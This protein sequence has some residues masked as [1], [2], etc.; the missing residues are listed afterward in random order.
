MRRLAIAVVA[1]AAVAG[2]SALAF[3]Q[4]SPPIT[5][6][7]DATVTPNK[8]GTKKKP[9]GV[10]LAVTAK[11]DIPEAYDPPL[12]DKVTVLFPKGGLYNG[13]EYPKCSETTL[14]RKGVSGC[15]KGSIMGSGSG[16]AMADDVP[17][18]PKVTIVNGGAKRVYFYT[19]MTNPA[20]V[21]APVVGKITK[22]SG[23]WSY[24]LEAQIPKSLQI[25]AGVPI[26]LEELT[27][28]GGKGDWIATTS[29]PADKRWRY[30]A[31]GLFTTGEKIVYDDAVPCR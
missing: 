13:A 24:R 2:G 4:S 12:V 3:A 28:K 20:R 18:F 14:D 1:A 8:A 17:T 5:M 9:Q 15:P 25:V 21:Q 11:F 22:L 27:L 19:V 16:R 23:Q 26:V 30:H 10:K 6:T 29:C 31:E 7:V